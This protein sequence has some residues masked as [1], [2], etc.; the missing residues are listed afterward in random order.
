MNVEQ[1]RRAGLR[2]A[3]AAGAEKTQAAIKDE[4]SCYDDILKAAISDAG[5]GTV[6]AKVLESNPEW[7]SQMLQ[8]IPDLG[9]YRDDLVKKAAT[10]PSAALNAL[11]SAP[12]LCGL[13][14]GLILAAGSAAVS[15]GNISAIH[16]KD[17]AGF[18]CQFTMYWINNG[19]TQP[20]HSYPNTSDWKWSS[21]LLLGQSQTMAC[22]N[23]AL[24][25]APLEAG[26]EVWIYVDIKSGNKHNESLLRFTYDPTTVN[27]AVFAISGT[28][29]DNTLGFSQITAAAPMV[30]VTIAND[31]ASCSPDQVE[32]SR[33]TD[34][35]VQWHMNTA[36]YV[37]TG[38]DIDNDGKNDFGAATISSEGTVMT[39]TDTV[40]DL[41]TFTYCVLYKNTATGEAGSFD[42]GIKNKN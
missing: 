24:N 19:Q 33:A 27:C 1:Q 20:A 17:S 42:P 37:F 25:D 32:V 35:G 12:N 14:Q 15:Q 23:F 29:T 2:L 5:L 22:R 6:V 30:Q 28:T 9:E 10:S 13:Q 39:V 31:K 7:A 34:T 18:D 16:L 26:D 41:E 38:I 4:S 21:V 40:R 8:H 36:G 3:V 11:R